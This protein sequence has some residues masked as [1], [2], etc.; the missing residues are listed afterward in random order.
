MKVLIILLL[1]LAVSLNGELYE[2]IED[3]KKLAINE[4]SLINHYEWLELEMEINLEYLR[5]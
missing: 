5:K 1:N 3:L 2:A 4:E